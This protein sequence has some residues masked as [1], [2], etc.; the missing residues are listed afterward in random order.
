MEFQKTDLYSFQK[1]GH[2]QADEFYDLVGQM[3]QMEEHVHQDLLEANAKV[4]Y[5]MTDKVMKTIMSFEFDCDLTIC[6]SFF[7][8]YDL[9]PKWMEGN[10]DKVEV[11]RIESPTKLC[12]GY[13]VKFPLD[14]KDI[15]LHMRSISLTYLDR[16]TNG[17]LNIGKTLPKDATSFFGEPVA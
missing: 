3:D 15:T 1:W 10:N 7:F 17:I 4:Y 6:S 9:I 13:L 12:A 11:A 8:E 5:K 14:G 2:S 16:K